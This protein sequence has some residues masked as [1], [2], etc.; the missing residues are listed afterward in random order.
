MALD[1]D[2]YAIAEL[3]GADQ[4]VVFVNLACCQFVA[5]KIK[6][7]G[8]LADPVATRFLSGLFG[9]LMPYQSSSRADLT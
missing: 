6:P 3:H 2:R 4:T 8:E 5:V 9:A 1:S 7:L